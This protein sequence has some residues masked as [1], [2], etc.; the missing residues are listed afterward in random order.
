[1]RAARRRCKPPGPGENFGPIDDPES[2][3]FRAAYERDIRDTATAR[4]TLQSRLEPLL[5][6][7]RVAYIKAPHETLSIEKR[8]MGEKM[9]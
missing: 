5:S 4:S 3:A 7:A 2:A 9:K 1:M 6:P 8:Y